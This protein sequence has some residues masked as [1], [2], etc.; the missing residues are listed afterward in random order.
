MRISEQTIRQI[1]QAIDIVEVIQDYVPLK[2]RGQNYWANCPFHDERSPSFSVSAQKGIY[3]CF[4]C[5]KAGDAVKFVMEINK[6]GYVEAL[7]RLAEKYH[8]VIEQQA[9]SPQEVQS[10]LQKESLYLVMNF[11][12][13]FFEEQLWQTD[14]G[15]RL[16]LAYFKERGLKE[17]TIKDFGLGYSPDS[18]NE[19]LQAAQKNGYSIQSLKEAGLVIENEQGKIYDRFRGRVMFPIHDLTGK[20]I[21]FGARTLKRDDKPKYLN[22][23]E[24]IIYNKSDTLYGLYEAKTS[25]RKND[26]VYLT[27]G[28]LDVISAVQA[29]ISNTVASAGTSLT[30][31]QIKTL[32]K[33]ASLIT[34]L[35]DGDSAGIKAA[36]RGIELILENGIDV[37]VVLFPEGEDPDSYIQKYGAAAFRDFIVSKSQDFILFKVTTVAKE[38][39]S[40]PL[41]RAALLQDIASNIAKIKDI[42]KREAYIKT[43]ASLLKIKE[44]DFYTAVNS[45]IIKAFAISKNPAS[46]YA[47]YTSQSS[48]AEEITKDE[49][50]ENLQQQN[51]FENP[52]LPQEKEFIRILMLYGGIPLGEKGR[53]M[54]YMFEE[55]KELKFQSSDFY[56]IITYY[57][58]LDPNLPFPT[59]QQVMREIPYATRE[60]VANLLIDLPLPSKNWLDKYQITAPAHD[61]MLDKVLYRNMLHFKYRYVEKMC[62]ELIEHI[63]E[64]EKSKADFPIIENLMLKYQ[65][66]TK[67]RLELAKLLGIVISR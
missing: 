48:E 15:Q 21:A 58:R 11:A 37:R 20:V 14:E 52:L 45:E 43:T 64:E 2:K 62:H 49:Q 24:T 5:G 8:I 65:H 44:E 56:S 40:E 63:Q 47:N 9:L 51:F 3:K 57:Q 30:Q 34:V 1:E 33:F 22:S 42:L 36:N 35:Y 54:D 31:E 19:L 13:R 60:I 66:L 23:P 4:G 46:N 26:N 50:I 18:R 10:S 38:I 16:G 25:I 17:Q 55:A 29:G 53:L 41:K 61:E 12:K 59:P 32:K 6:I 28:Y 27:E 67:Q 7:T 39:A